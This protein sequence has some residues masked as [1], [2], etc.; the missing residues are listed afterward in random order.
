MNVLLL[1]GL[2]LH[3]TV[4]PVVVSGA[5]GRVG[6]AVVKSLIAR[7]GSADG[8]YILARDLDKAQSLHADVQCLCAAYDDVDALNAAFREVPDKFRLFVAC[9]N[10]PAQATLESNVCRAAHAAGCGY[11]VKLSTASAVLDMK[12]GGP[13]GAH[14]EVE[15][16]L[17]ELALPHAVLRPN[18]FMDE[19]TRGAFLG[20]GG[21]L[22]AAD[23]CTHPFAEARISMVDVRDV[24]DCAAALLTADAP[25]DTVG[26]SYDLTGPAAVSLG[27]DLASALS[28][29]RPRSVSIHAC[30][31]DAFI[32]PRALPPPIAANLAGFFNVLARE[33]ADVARRRGARARASADVGN[34]SDAFEGGAGDEDG[35]ARAEDEETWATGR[36]NSPS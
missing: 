16:L 20:V 12:E 15:E 36:E 26:D 33:C 3:A 18:L 19:I 13:Y 32:E 4:P 6:S 30:T 17:R 9:N 1:V 25:R 31:V 35:R 8:I 14:L 22:R 27:D 7:R 2:S 5:T 28:S 23:V 29:I 24:A 21:P 11:A 10:G 34:A